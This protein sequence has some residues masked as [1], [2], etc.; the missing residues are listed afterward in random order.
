MPGKA[1]APYSF[2]WGALVARAFHVG[3]EVAWLAGWL[4]GTP[5]YLAAVRADAAAGWCRG[6]FGGQGVGVSMKRASRGG[7]G[8]GNGNIAEAGMKRC[9]AAAWDPYKGEG[10]SE[11]QLGGA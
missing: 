3:K 9:M 7:A 1:G 2:A 10:S 11:W 4:A 5:A 6:M 8:R